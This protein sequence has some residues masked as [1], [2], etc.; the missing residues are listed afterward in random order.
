MN[1]NA[2][3]SILVTAFVLSADAVADNVER[4]VQAM[5]GAR[6]PLVEAIRLAETQGNGPA[7]DAELLAASGRSEYQIK[8]LNAADKTVRRYK[9]D[10]MTG[11]ITAAESEPFETLFRRPKAEVVLKSPMDL[12]TAAITAQKTGGG[13]AV[14][15]EL[16]PE[17]DA[18]VYDVKLLK[19]NTLQAVKINAGGKVASAQ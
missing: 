9:I 11:K 18:V 16:D 5:K 4:T 8:V 3:T 10:A 1:R 13:I 7:I 17:R 15:A 2:L 19:G 12:A 6:Y 14:G